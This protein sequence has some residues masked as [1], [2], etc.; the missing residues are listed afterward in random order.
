MSKKHD[1]HLKKWQCLIKKYR[2][3]GMKV[4]D[5]CAAN[6]I[7]KYQYYYWVAKVRS[8]CYEEA[9]NQLQKE[10]VV[11]N[12]VVPVQVQNGTFVEIR[13]EMVS[14]VPNQEK[15]SQPAAVVQ[16]GSIRIEIMSNA[17]TSL[18]K[19]LLETVRYA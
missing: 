19:H 18:I 9:V 12:A 10:T 14:E 11:S 6:N 13:P 8:E 17:S 5:W 2:E 7:S 15:L 1:Y 3:S 4:K 16:K